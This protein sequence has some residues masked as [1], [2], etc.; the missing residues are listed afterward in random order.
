MAIRAFKEVAKDNGALE[1]ARPMAARN[2]DFAGP[3]DQLVS[4]ILPEESRVGRRS[5]DV[6]IR[7]EEQCVSR[8]LH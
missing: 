2:A 1:L 4:T 3:V 6:P 5:G 7:P 8:S